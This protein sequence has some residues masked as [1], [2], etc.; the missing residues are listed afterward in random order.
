MEGQ[1]KYG[2]HCEWFEY[3]LVSNRINDKGIKEMMEH[4]KKPSKKVCKM[5]A[6][7]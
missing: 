6:K 5:K 1:T 2:S 7:S 4:L 3:R